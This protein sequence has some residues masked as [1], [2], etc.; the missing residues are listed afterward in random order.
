M[1]IAAA[2]KVVP[3]DQDI[4]VAGDRTLDYSKAKNTISVYD[5]NALEVAAQLAAEVEGSAAVAITAGPAS[6]DEAKLKK[7][8]LARG[9]DELFM[10]ADDACAGM[11]AKATAA[12]LAKLVA[13]IGDVDLVV[14]GDG[15]AD[16]Y[17][18]QVDV[19]LACKL[20]WPV[21]NAATKV[22]CKGDVLEVERT[23]EDAARDYLR[24]F[25]GSNT[26]GHAAAYPNESVHTSAERLVMQDARDEV[27]AVYR[28]AGLESS[29][30]WRSGEDHIACELEYMQVMSERA[31][32]ACA[33][34][35]MT[36]AA[37][38]LMA[39]HHFLDDHLLGWVGFLTDEMLKFAQT[40][41]YRG[42]AHLT[43]GFLTEDKAFLDEV[44]AEELDV[45][46]QLHGDGPVA[47]ADEDAGET[48]PADPSSQVA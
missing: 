13:Q 15:S 7:S 23:L 21:V 26:T 9:V 4:K 45:E 25:I 12:E 5:L 27:L 44:L 28:A 46:A 8:A 43:R 36:K 18:Q 3:D 24:V 39:Q 41:L 48:A 2:F 32:A 33:A 22:T 47:D 17:A 37:S 38:T 6:I 29:S 11:D 16:N 42:L 19:Q 20:G 40:D 10:T 31:A 34:G 30:R 1:K 14:C 35:D